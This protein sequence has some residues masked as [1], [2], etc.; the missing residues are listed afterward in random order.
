MINAGSISVFYCDFG[1]YDNLTV[2][3]LVPLAEEYLSLPYQAIKARLAGIQP[4]DEKWS[5]DDC[6]HFERLVSDKTFV[7]VVVTVQ[8]D[9]LYQCDSILILKLIDT[10]A[11]EDVHIDK[12]L[13]Q[14]GIA[15]EDPKFLK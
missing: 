13:M 10:S 6:K 1:Y 9:I 2:K 8:K 14:Q 7:S 15:K 4:R 11:A 12:L 5:M 3:Q